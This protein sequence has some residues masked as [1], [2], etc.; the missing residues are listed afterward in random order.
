MKTEKILED[1]VFDIEKRIQKW[2]AVYAKHG[3]KYAGA[4][5]LETYREILAMINEKMAEAKGANHDSW[6]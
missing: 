6:E 5:R 1:V 3:V 4:T 2:K